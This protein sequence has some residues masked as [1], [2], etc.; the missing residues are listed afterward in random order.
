MIGELGLKRYCLQL[1]HWLCFR[2][3]RSFWILVGPPIDTIPLFTHVD[4]YHVDPIYGDFQA[5][6]TTK[7]GGYAFTREIPVMGI[8][9]GREAATQSAYNLLISKNPTV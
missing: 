3:C 7:N 6:G 8:L 5:D 9:A 2:R 4:A 1:C